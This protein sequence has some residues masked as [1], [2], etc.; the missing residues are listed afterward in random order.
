ME[1]TFTITM[2]EDERLMNLAALGF[3]SMRLPQGE[4]ATILNGLI[5]KLTK[6][7]GADSELYNRAP[8]P[9]VFHPSA[10]VPCEA[11]DYFARDRKGNI[12][13]GPPE[14]AE[15]KAV[16]IVGTNELAS[17][18]AGKSPFLKVIFSGGQA[19]CFDA[20]LWPHI[21]KKTGQDAELYF[22]KSGSY[23]NIVG[24]RA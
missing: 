4:P 19:A 3:A 10:P 21:V 22:V 20:A 1:R 17:K 7:N 13:P 18:T 23:W 15:L 12:P 24:V 8:D 5:A 16:K 6:A 14:G 9:A 11:R 2:H